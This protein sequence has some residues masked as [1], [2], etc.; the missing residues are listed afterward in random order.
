MSARVTSVTQIDLTDRIDPYGIAAAPDGTLWVTL[1]H[2]GAVAR[3]SADG[4][5]QRFPVGSPTSRPSVVTVARDGTV[6]FT[7]NGDDRIG[8]LDAHGALRAVHLAPGS[9]PY[10]IWAADDG[11]VW[12]TE[13]TADRIGRLDRDGSV[14]HVALPARSPH[15]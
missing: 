7:C 14:T 15:S 4:G 5:Q 13:S 11:A 10:G 6:W 2:S 12:F 9:G 3:L 8:A 1:V